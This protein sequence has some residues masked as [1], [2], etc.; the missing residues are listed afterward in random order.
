MNCADD[1]DIG[2]CQNCIEIQ[3]V[4]LD[5]AKTQPKCTYCDNDAL[6]IEECLP[7]QKSTNDIICTKKVQVCK[8][9]IVKCTECD[10]IICKDCAVNGRCNLHME[11]CPSGFHYV[12]PSI[13]MSCANCNKKQ[14]CSCLTKS[15]RITGE[16][17]IGW[18]HT[19]CSRHVGKCSCGSMLYDAPIFR[20][21]FNDC[22]QVSCDSGWF[23]SLKSTMIYACHDHRTECPICNRKY[24][25]INACLITLKG[26]NGTQQCCVNCY[27]LFKN[28]VVGLLASRL[29]ISFIRMIPKDILNMIFREHLNNI[30]K[31]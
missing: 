11:W 16:Y 26:V 7:L 9:H 25:I 2:F 17:R 4:T 19:L 10:K 13:I 28:G 12:L 5:L 24:P 27:S 22:E 15:H 20:C 23:K 3:E 1:D 8:D 31:I 21:T 18:T 14:C 29:H 30:K 6:F